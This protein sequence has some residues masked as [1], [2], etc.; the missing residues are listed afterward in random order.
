M[1]FEHL[2]T[3]TRVVSS[4]YKLAA[5]TLLLYYLVQHVA[6]K[7]RDGRKVYRTSRGFR[8]QFGG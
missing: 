4:I 6:R 8:R 5:T 1:N 3:T 7:D 2:F